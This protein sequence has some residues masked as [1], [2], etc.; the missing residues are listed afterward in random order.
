MAPGVREFA[1]FAVLAALL[2]T[3]LNAAHGDQCRTAGRLGR[4]APLDVGVDEM[5]DVPSQ[6]LVEV[7]VQ[8]AAAKQRPDAHR[9]HM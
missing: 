1:G 7:V 2:F 6:F 8:R 9:E 5:L 4:H 3:L